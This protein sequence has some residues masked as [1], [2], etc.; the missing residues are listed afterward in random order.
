M[1]MVGNIHHE[2]EDE[3]GLVLIH[4]TP[5]FP[6]HTLFARLSFLGNA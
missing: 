4:S 5:D 1:G 3:I 6:F 2:E